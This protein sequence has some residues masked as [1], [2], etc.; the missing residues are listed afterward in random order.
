M[1]DHRSSSRVGL[2][3]GMAAALILWARAPFAAR[4]LWGEDGARFLAHAMEGG[5]FEPLFRSLAGYF[6]FLPR[7]VGWLA[8]LGPLEMAPQ[9][10]FA[11]CASAVAWFATTIFLSADRHLDRQWSRIALALT[12]VLLPI[13][14]F[15]SIAN[16]T[17]LHFLM[18]CA[19][20]VVLVGR[21]ERS[22][23]KVNGV[24]LVAMAGLTSP[25][26]AGLAPLV[27]LRVWWDRRES[28][29]L[30][31]APVVA[32]WALGLAVQLA[33]MATLV[34]EGREMTSDRSITRAG[35]LF[36]ERVV[37]YNLVPFWP[38]VSS[39]DGVGGIDADLVVRSLAALVVLGS[40]A[41]AVIGTARH[42]RSWGLTERAELVL[43]VPIAGL[44]FF[45]AASMLTGPEPRYAVFPAFSLVWAILVVMESLGDS[46]RAPRSGRLVSVTIALVLA[47]SVVTHWVPSPIR[48]T[49]P[50]WAA[51]LESAARECETNPDGRVEIPILP[52][53]WT[54]PVDCSDV[55]EG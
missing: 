24:V 27:V 43:T 7:L 50:T 48:R 29:S 38:R 47:A 22:G 40:V 54:V 3:V 18:L 23:R 13:L 36:L 5:L 42:Q 2:L 31:P 9:V 39:T 21:Q 45:A 41:A 33:M 55:L 46:A 12:P 6:H 14:G 32:G 37:S 28:G 51:G 25:L 49:G 4:N 15:E 11:A 44:A 20:S 35:F 19:A 10:V 16:V 34:D 1:T 26:T 17:N 8:A 52:E 30:S 53:G